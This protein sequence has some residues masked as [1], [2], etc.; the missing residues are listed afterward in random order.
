MGN[1][2]WKAAAVPRLFRAINLKLAICLINGWVGDEV[3]SRCSHNLGPWD[4]LDSIQLF[5]SIAKLSYEVDELI[6]KT[7][8]KEVLYFRNLFFFYKLI[9]KQYNVWNHT[10]K[11]GGCGNWSIHMEFSFQ[12]ALCQ[13][14]YCSCKLYKYSTIFVIW[15]RVP[16][17]KSCHFQHLNEDISL[18]CF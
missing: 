18:P 16:I 12:T 17:Y 5:Q 4:I 11:N 9:S 2:R 6:L 7:M 8:I 14:S 3:T 10:C 13:E 15:N 1:L